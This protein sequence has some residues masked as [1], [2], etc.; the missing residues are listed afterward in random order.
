MTKRTTGET[1]P[2]DRLELHR[3]LK[4]IINGG[5]T[6]LLSAP[7]LVV[8]NHVAVHAGFADCRVSIGAKAV[9]TLT[10]THRTSIRRGIDDLLEVGIIRRRKQA[11]AR[12]AAVYEVRVPKAPSMP[13]PA[14]A[15]ALADAVARLLAVVAGGTPCA[16]G[17]HTLCPQGT[18]HVPPGDTPCA[19]IHVLPVPHVLHGEQAEPSGLRRGRGPRPVSG[20]KAHRLQAAQ[21]KPRH[22][23]GARIENVKREVCDG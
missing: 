7:A 12:R 14:V 10:G 13:W 5:Y 11:T 23:A 4:A 6:G 18:Q 3:R 21:I 19:P 20:G 2:V 8:L 1:G 9:S 22:V 15:D 17:G 16:P